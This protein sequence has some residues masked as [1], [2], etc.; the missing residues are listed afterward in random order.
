[1]GS[2]PDCVMPKTL[3]WYLVLPCNVL[4]IKR[5]DQGNIVG[6][7]VVDYIVSLDGLPYQYDHDMAFQSGTISA[8]SKQRHHVHDMT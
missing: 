8:T 2:V 6:L 1:M 7:P 4:T 5:L 3:K